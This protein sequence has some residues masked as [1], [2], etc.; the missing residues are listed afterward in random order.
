MLITRLKNV[1]RAA[2]SWDLSER[3]AAVIAWVV[4]AILLLSAVGKAKQRSL[5]FDEF[6]T[7]NIAAKGRFSEMAASMK[8]GADSIPPYFHFLQHLV[9]ELGGPTEISLRIL[10]A[11]AVATGFLCLY[12]FLAPKCGPIAA[13]AGAL[14]PMA[15]ASF[16]Y[17]YEGRPYG[18]L[19]G[20][21]CAVAL[22]WSRTETTRFATP[23]LGVLLATATL[24]HP[25]GLFV[26][27]SIAAAEAALS[28]LRRSWRPDTWMTLIAAMIPI[29]LHFPFLLRTKQNFS[30]HLFTSASLQNALTSMQSLF[31]TL[32]PLPLIIAVGYIFLE[33]TAI[34]IH[35]TGLLPPV[36]GSP[37]S[38]F[39]R[40]LDAE[41]SLGIALFLVLPFITWLACRF[42]GWGLVGRY[43]IPS[44]V[45]AGILW[46]VAAS[47]ASVAWRV[48]TFA[49][50]ALL[51]GGRC[52]SGMRS[53]L[54]E[55]P[56]NIP[57]KYKAILQF[58]E[59]N[60][61]QTVVIHDAEA[62]LQCWHAL[63]EQ[64]RNH[65]IFVADP[66]IAASLSKLRSD[67]VDVTMHGF[68][69]TTGARV[70]DYSSFTQTHNRFILVAR[71][72][73]FEWLPSKL[74]ED[75]CTLRLQALL[76]QHHLIDVSCPWSTVTKL[77]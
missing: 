9:L 32:W 67:S 66:A 6:M 3:R 57:Q 52:L 63:P 2:I 55:I 4:S 37:R 45:G 12:F 34:G 10:P 25:F 24:V 16:T 42:V 64:S 43:I 28:L 49:A 77:P 17:A 71:H 68:G 30:A 38:K 8:A 58:V 76:G 11:I 50:L 27:L 48:A 35:T 39:S 46:G 18:I 44:T 31:G 21:T 36:D 54:L 51:V 13:L 61:D 1:F 5:W 72:G 7:Y 23:V 74:I 59:S 41:I 14:L 56:S 47:R 29:I 73:S 20:L 26:T 15:S 75:G 62:F 22:V 60:I 19:I 33:M 69:K 65:F 40:S 53:F 70:M